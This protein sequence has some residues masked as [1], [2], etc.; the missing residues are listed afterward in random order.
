MYKSFTIF[1]FIDEPFVDFID[2]RR[3]WLLFEKSAPLK[4][5]T[6]VAPW[7]FCYWLSLPANVAPL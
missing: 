1:L 5:E 3:L 7:V 2:L 6:V 4:Q